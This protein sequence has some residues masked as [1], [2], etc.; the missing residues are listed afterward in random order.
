MRTGVIDM[1]LLLYVIG[2]T[3][4]PVTAY[5]IAKGMLDIYIAFKDYITVLHDL[6]KSPIVTIR[7]NDNS[8]YKLS[9]S[10]EIIA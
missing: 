6:K 3:F 5:E 7:K 1:D 2:L 9:A 4:I 8:R 10:Y